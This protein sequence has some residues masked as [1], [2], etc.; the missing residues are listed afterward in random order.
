M[1]ESAEYELTA[2]R[3]SERYRRDHRFHAIAQSVVTSVLREHGPVDPERADRDA[4]DIAIKVAAMVLETVF[5][6]DAE[7]NA[8]RAIADQYKKL[9]LESLGFRPMPPLIAP[10]TKKEGER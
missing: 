8:Q 7:L 1:V 10:T 5:R 6:D 3:A 9:A 2:M 4:Y